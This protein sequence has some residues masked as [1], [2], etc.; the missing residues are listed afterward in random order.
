ME[1]LAMVT[2]H[3]NQPLEANSW[4]D[5]RKEGKKNIHPPAKLFAQNQQMYISK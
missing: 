4:A 3:E 5:R 1:R 2:S